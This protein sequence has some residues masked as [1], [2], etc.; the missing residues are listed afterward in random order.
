[1]QA[2]RAQRWMVGGAAAL[3]SSVSVVRGSSRLADR[4]IDN[5]SVGGFVTAADGGTLEV[6]LHLQKGTERAPSS[7]TTTTTTGLGRG[8]GQVTTPAPT[9]LPL[10]VTLRSATTR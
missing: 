10:S 1:M 9:I 8:P 7:S 5:P 6:L 3:W 4:G 2:K